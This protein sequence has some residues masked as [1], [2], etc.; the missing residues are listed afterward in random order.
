MVSIVSNEIWA[1]DLPDTLWACDTTSLNWNTWDNLSDNSLLGV[2][3]TSTNSTY[4]TTWQNNQGCQRDTLIQIYIPQAPVINTSSTYIPPTWN[5]QLSISGEEAPYNTTGLAWNN[6]QLTLDTPG[7][8]PFQVIDRWGCAY[9]D[10]LQIDPITSVVFATTN[11]EN[12][13]YQNPYL[14]GPK[15]EKISVYNSVGQLIQATKDHENWILP[16]HSAPRWVM[17]QGK[18]YPISWVLDK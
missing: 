9:V 12:W 2:S 1:W 3:N 13:R 6:G 15:H 18:F 11:T 17:V 7:I 5:C 16:D 14:I 4:T 8:Y 10:T